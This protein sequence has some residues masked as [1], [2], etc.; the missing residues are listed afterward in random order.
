ME[1]R[2]YV[3][4]DECG[5]VV[6]ERMDLDTA[7]I[8]IKALMNTYYND[9]SVKYTIGP[10]DIVGPNDYAQTENSWQKETLN[11][12]LKSKETEE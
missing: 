1:E 7:I 4:Y 8:L 9:W 10:F 12:L 2:T 6:A 5:H 11:E 3:V